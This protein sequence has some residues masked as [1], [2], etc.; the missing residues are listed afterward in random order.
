MS[1]EN[2]KKIKQIRKRQCFLPITKV[3]AMMEPLTVGDDIVMKTM[4]GSP[5]VYDTELIKLLFRHADFFEMK[6]KP[7]Y[8]G[9][10]Q[11]VSLFDKKVLIWALYNASYGKIGKQPLTCPKCD[12]NFEDELHSSQLV[13]EKTFELI[14]DKE[15][16]FNE[17]VVTKILEFPDIEELDRIEFDLIIPTIERHLLMLKTMSI[18]E[19]KDNTNK[20]NSL[21]SKE[22]EMVLVT[23]EMRVYNVSEV[24]SETGETTITTDH[25][26][27]IGELRKTISEYLPL[28]CITEVTDE[29]N[30]QFAKYEP[31]FSKEMTCP[32]CFH[33]FD[34][35]VD[36]E[37]IMIRQ[38][39]RLGS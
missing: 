22:D 12:E 36:M 5:E 29:F 16:P 7:N 33:K 6:T 21:L 20:F 39:L 4:I 28:D 31:N 25:I 38:Y 18:D 14:W 37:T 26:N 30:D 3:K 2:L 10:I 17:T 35:A 11:N 27:S 13:N 32:K 1:F 15:T 19:I 8:D 9:F 34:F 24:N 23:K